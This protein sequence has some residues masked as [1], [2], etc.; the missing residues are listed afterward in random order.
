MKIF[1]TII[2]ASCFLNTFAQKEQDIN[3]ELLS[4]EY[5][6]WN[7]QDKKEVSD[8]II[9]KAQKLTDNG[10]FEEAI[11]ELNRIEDLS[12][13]DTN[14]LLYKKSLNNF[15]L[16]YYDNAYNL[17]L[18][19]PDSL[20]LHEN[21]YLTL[22]LFTLNEMKKWDEC[23]LLLLANIDT[24]AIQKSEIEKLPIEI[25]YK[26]PLKAKHLSGFFPGIGQYYAGYPLKGT[27]SILLHASFC[28]VAIE[29][30]I[31]GMYITSI[32]YGLNPVVR[33]YLGGKQNS[34]RLA[35]AKNN[36]QILKIQKKYLTDIQLL[37]K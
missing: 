4:I 30:I 11:N 34:Y 15:M 9:L 36:K 12:S 10:S 37:I 29:S 26:S 17:M 1:L 14:E 6:I 13:V 27:A 24:T 16:G 21:K 2:I 18:D 25:K 7:T 8:L 23:K 31:S 32:I 35:D 5:S 22:W 3:K 28:L 20:R 33:L 19:M